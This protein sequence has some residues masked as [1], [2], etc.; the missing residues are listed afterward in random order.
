MGRRRHANQAVARHV[1]RGDREPG[2]AAAA[3]ISSDT[4]SAQS[5]EEPQINFDPQCALSERE[6]PPDRVRDID[7][8]TL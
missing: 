8:F 2:A 6:R 5:L 3:A 1:L 4:Y 7:V